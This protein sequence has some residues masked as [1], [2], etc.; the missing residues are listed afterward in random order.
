MTEMEAMDIVG[1]LM[2]TCGSWDEANIGSWVELLVDLEHVAAAR[3][4]TKT[5]IQT[6][7]KPQ[8]P[9]YGIWLD[10]YRSAVAR[11]FLDEQYALSK[12]K[13]T[14]VTLSEHLDWLLMRNDLTELG[15]W[16]HHASKWRITDKDVRIAGQSA[17]PWAGELAR[18]FEAHPN[19]SEGATGAQQ[20][21]QKTF[22]FK[23]P[24]GEFMRDPEEKQ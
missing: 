1:R 10:A 20:G 2:A 16:A 14:E 8:R 17:I 12:P 9:P 6:W 23:R 22:R 18:W 4:A 3:E 7:K 15:V 13:G 5:T 24:I 19:W 21:E 11:G